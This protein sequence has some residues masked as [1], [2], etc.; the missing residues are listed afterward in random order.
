MD[1]QKPP[2]GISVEDWAATPESVRALVYTL[3]A[4]VAS[5]QE[6]VTQ[7]QETVIPLQQRVSELEERVKQDS[8][9]SSKA[10]STDPPQAR[11]YP[12]RKPSGRKQGGQKGHQGRGRELKPPEQVNEIVVSKPMACEGCGTLLLGEDISPWRHQVTELPRIEPEVIEYQVHTLT[13]LVCGKRNRG[14]WPDERPSG[15][16]GQRVQATIAYLS[17]RCGVSRRDVEEILA[18]VFRL[19]ISLGS[20]PAQEQRV[21][22]AL[23]QPVTEARAFVARQPVVNID[24]TGWKEKNESR[25]L[26]VGTTPAVTVFHL[27]QTRG[28]DGVRLLVGQEYGGIVGSDRWSAYNWLD[29]SQRQLCWAHLKRDFQALVDR[30]GESAIIGS[31]LLTQVETLFSHW[32]GLREGSLSRL[33]YQALMQPI[34]REVEALLELATLAVAHRTTRATCQ[35][36]LKRKSALWSFVD[37][38]HVEPTNNAAERALRRG[39]IWRRR[40]F[41]T[42]SQTGSRFVE[43]IM[44][45]VT[46][47][48]QQQRDVLDYLTQACKAHTLGKAPPSLLPDI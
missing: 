5:L 38:A 39:V 48:R 33:E 9:N 6:T 8:S 35:N 10:P 1:S 32:Y 19:D 11:K 47:L 29:T 17:G 45:T 7:L 34:R 24:E 15:R 41:G 14:E 3:L 40:S 36:I 28:G 31:R 13:C 23:L 12:K 21:S 46:T 44:T 43:R 37:Q 20:I 42:Q 22:Q 30:G 2:A 18:T 27:T 25:W 4:T 16:F 26:W